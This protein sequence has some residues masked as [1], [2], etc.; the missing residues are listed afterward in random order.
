TFKITAKR[1]DHDFI[2][3][4]NELNLTLGNAI[5]DIFPNIKAK[6]KQ[7]DINLRLEIRMDGAYLSYE[8]VQGAGGLPVGTAGNGMLMLSG[9]IDSPVA[10]YYAMKRGVEIEAV[11]FASPPYTSEQ[12]LQKAKDL[13]KKL[14]PYVGSIQF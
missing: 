2:Q 4:S 12:A 6:M 5:F 3:D 8:T 14:T 10:R 1:S 13:T 7:P 11:H 9:G